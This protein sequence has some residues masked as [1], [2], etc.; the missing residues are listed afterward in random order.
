MERK[1]TQMERKTGLLLVEGIDDLH[2]FANLF[3]EHGVPETF[4]MG[5]TICTVT[6]FPTQRPCERWK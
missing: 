4:E 1:G 5:E 2:V 3:R 6:S